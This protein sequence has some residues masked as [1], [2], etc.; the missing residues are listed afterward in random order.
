MPKKHKIRTSPNLH[1]GRHSLIVIAVVSLAT[2]IGVAVA[3]GVLTIYSN[4]RKAR[5]EIERL[6]RKYRDPL[7]L[8]SQDLQ[9]RIYNITE[10][11]ILS[12]LH[13]SQDHKDWLIIYIAFLFG[14]Y[15]CWT[16][17]GASKHSLLASLPRNMAALIS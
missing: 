8:A 3:S 9:S 1:H 7:L 13:G 15:L 16:R 17:F 10:Q 2:S 5:H 6:L 12:F 11:D 14:Q 4:D